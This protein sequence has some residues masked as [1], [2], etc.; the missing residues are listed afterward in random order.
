MRERHRMAW[1]DSASAWAPH[2]VA[3]TTWKATGNTEEA[4][5][6]AYFALLKPLV[7]SSLSF[8]QENS[9]CN[10]NPA[11]A[12]CPA[13]TLP[14]VTFEGPLLLVQVTSTDRL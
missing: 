8:F 2:V 11:K 5:F 14:G 1:E 9:S 13:K 6:T 12:S 3:P 7:A 4:F 10:F